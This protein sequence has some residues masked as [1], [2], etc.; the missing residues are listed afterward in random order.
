MVG[1]DDALV[2]DD[3]RGPVG[4]AGVL[5]QHAER[6]ADGVVGVPHDRVRDLARERLPIGEPRLVAVERV[7]ADPD[8]VDLVVTELLEVILEAADLGRAHER[9][10]QGVPVKDVPLAG[11]VLVAH[12]PLLALVVS[13]AGPLGSTCPIM[14]IVC[15]FLREGSARLRARRRA[16]GVRGAA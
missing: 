5:L 15:V 3:D 1:A 6:A 14:L 9:E 13:D 8:D 4:D 7:G 2:V 16:A 10:I 11:V 12:L